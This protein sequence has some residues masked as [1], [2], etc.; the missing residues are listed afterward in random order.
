MS[1]RRE[2]WKSFGISS[3]MSLL[4]L[5]T[6]LLAHPDTLRAPI[7]VTII[8]CYLTLGSA[9]TLHV[10][11]QKL[12]FGNTAAIEQHLRR[13]R[14]DR[15]GFQPYALLISLP[16][17]LFLWAMLAS[18]LQVLSWMG[19]PMRSYLPIALAAAVAVLWAI[20]RAIPFLLA[21]YEKYKNGVP[22]RRVLYAQRVSQTAVSHATV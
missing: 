14:S 1:E 5:S 12:V 15:Y 16:K 10:K 20:T 8:L 4:S 22:V 2:E 21:K 6:A 17:A 11:H 7:Y 18:S 13:A 9:A 19:A 3:A